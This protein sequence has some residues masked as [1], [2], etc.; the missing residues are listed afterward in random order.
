MRWERG[1]NDGM[2]DVAVHMQVFA[3]ISANSFTLLKIQC[4]FSETVDMK[5]EC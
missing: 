3:H 5:P 2:M 4:V 1:S